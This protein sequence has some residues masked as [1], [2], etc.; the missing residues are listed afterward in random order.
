MCLPEWLKL[1]TLM[2]GRIGSCVEELELLNAGGRNAK[3]HNTL[4]DSLAV[5]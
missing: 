5:F 2:I 1:K 3:W 4:E